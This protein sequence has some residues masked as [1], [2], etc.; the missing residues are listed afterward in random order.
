MVVF[1]S[2]RAFYDCCLCELV[3]SCKKYDLDKKLVSLASH[4]L[5]T[6][7][8]NVHGFNLQYLPFLDVATVEV[9][10]IAT[11]HDANPG[12][13]M[14]TLLPRLRS[15]EGIRDKRYKAVGKK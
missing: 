11:P 13:L 3:Y 8:H 2:Y 1:G 7:K 10:Q 12:D 9:H 4:D 5:Y 6:I 14:Y 15:L